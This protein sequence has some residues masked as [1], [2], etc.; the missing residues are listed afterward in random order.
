MDTAENLQKELAGC[1]DGINA[2]GLGSLDLKAIEKLDTL[3]A[4]AAGLGMNQGKK[5]IDNLSAVLKSFKD[6]KSTE[7]S[8]TIRMT[9]MDFYLKNTQGDSLEEL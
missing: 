4:A 1:V 7:D 8:V 5:L 9:A 2:A 6:G 3:S